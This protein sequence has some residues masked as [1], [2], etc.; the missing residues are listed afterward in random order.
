MNLVDRLVPGVTTVTLNARY[1]PLHGLVADEACNRDLDLPAA[2]SL[3]R[4][5]E[6]VI[7]AVSARHLN[8]DPASHRGLSQPH[9]YDKIAPR[10]GAGSVEIG[11]LAAPGVYAQPSWGFWPAYRG[12]ET[13][14]Q[15]TGTSEFAPG[16]QF[17]R[18]AVREGL[19][20]VLSL[21]ARNNLSTRILDDHVH[22][23]ICQSVGSADGMWLARL[24]AQPGISDERQTRAWTRR[25]TLRI[26]ARCL[27]LSS[28]RQVSDNVSRFLAYDDALSEDSVLAGSVITAQWRGL[29][30]RNH[31]VGAWRGLWAWIV[32]GIDG[33]TPRATLGE[34][35]ADAL[36][37]Q[38]VGAFS[39]QLPATRTPD[40]HP[41]PAELDPGLKAS[42][43]PAWALSILLLGAQRARELSGHELTGFQGNDPEDI[44]EELAPAWLAGQVDAWRDRP[45][46]DFARWLVD[47]MVNRSQRLALR[48]ARPDARTGVLKIPSRV[49]LRDGFVFRDSRETGGQASLRLGQLAGVLAGVGLLAQEDGRWVVGPRGDL[50]V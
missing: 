32:N 47:V 49:Y 14:L 33:L 11:E 18:H 45:V 20:D 16:E 13:V 44:F 3:M 38:T 26:I 21:A 6:V 27:Q 23:C 36:P 25:Q 7:G 34:R 31:S 43:W 22:L 29:V 46:R 30:L 12:S 10:V 50:L 9:G 39:D 8:I 1:Y 48:K 40:R 15:I 19:G 41:A 2:Q 17:D 24:L 28:V 35:F 5:V 42:D 37:A 4:R